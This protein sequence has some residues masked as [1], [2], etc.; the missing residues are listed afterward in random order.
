ME[1][2]LSEGEDILVDRNGEE[3]RVPITTEALAN[4]IADKSLQRHPT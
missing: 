1:I 2:F 4:I 3:V